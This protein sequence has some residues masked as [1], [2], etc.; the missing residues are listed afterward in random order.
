LIQC[1]NE[2]NNPESKSL[3]VAAERTKRLPG[4]LQMIVDDA[5]KQP[6]HVEEQ[7]SANPGIALYGAAIGCGVAGLFPMHSVLELWI[8]TSLSI[9]SFQ[10][11]YNWPCNYHL[12]AFNQGGNEYTLEIVSKEVN[13]FTLQVDELI[14]KEGKP[15]LSASQ[16]SQLVTLCETSKSLSQR[17]EMIAC[18]EIKHNRWAVVGHAGVVS[19]IMIGASTAVAGLKVAPILGLLGM[20]ASHPW[21]RPWAA[22]TTLFLAVAALPKS[23]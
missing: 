7:N 22:A 4:L 19:G 9:Y 8:P 17:V 6:A 5:V 10:L 14:F 11:A 20:V 23:H 3:V 16:R 18:T 2:A 21:V 15:K 1:S 12:G 13:A